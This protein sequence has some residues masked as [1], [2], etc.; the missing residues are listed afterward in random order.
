M[1]LSLTDFWSLVRQSKLLSGD[2]CKKYH[3]QFSQIATG[4]TT[5]SDLA[6]WLVTE[7]VISRYHAKV[8]L[9][10]QP[11]PFE[12]GAYRVYD[13]VQSGRLAGA[14]RAV[15]LKST[16][17]VLLHFQSGPAAQDAAA[18]ATLVREFDAICAITSPYLEQWHEAVSLGNF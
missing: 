12:Y 9:A 3:G 6:E 7:R 4:E 5:A 11:G 10:G 8:L 16:H 1:S 13:R 17:P 15:H 18:W 2:Q 14:F